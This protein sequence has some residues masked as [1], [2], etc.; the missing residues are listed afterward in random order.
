M[1]TLSSNLSTR[2]ECTFSP[3]GHRNENRLSITAPL[4]W[5]DFHF[6]SQ[7][8][9]F[10]EANRTPSFS[11]LSLVE[12]FRRSGYPSSSCWVPLSRQPAHESHFLSLPTSSVSTCQCFPFLCSSM[13]YKTYKLVCRPGLTT[14]L[15]L[16][17]HAVNPFSKMGL[18]KYIVQDL[19]S[20]SLPSCRLTARRNPQR[21]FDCLPAG[22]F[23]R[24]PNLHCSSVFLFR[25]YLS[26][27]V[28]FVSVLLVASSP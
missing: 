16:P 15:P 25:E 6:L 11:A 21:I 5:T 4:G 10:P 22:I 8:I 14:P 2:V 3:D 13:P 12:L 23:N 7:F 27:K 9:R 18:M 17:N 24:V 19:L 1:G 28:S 26:S 20:H